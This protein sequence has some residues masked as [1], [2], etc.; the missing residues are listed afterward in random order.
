MLLIELV[1]MLIAKLIELFAKDVPIM[2]EVT[3]ILKHA[4]VQLYADEL[5]EGNTSI[6]LGVARMQ[7]RRHAQMA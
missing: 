1:A 4:L 5:V 6:G 3:M 2:H 7:P